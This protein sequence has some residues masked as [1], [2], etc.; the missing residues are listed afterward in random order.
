MIMRSSV[1]NNYIPQLDSQLQYAMDYK[2]FEWRRDDILYTIFTFLHGHLYNHSIT[3]NLTHMYTS[4][5]MYKN[6]YVISWNELF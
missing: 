2:V 5:V 4:L 3:Y 6:K 1:H